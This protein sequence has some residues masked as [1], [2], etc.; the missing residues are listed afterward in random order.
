MH[1]S[2]RYWF[3]HE[4]KPYERLPYVSIPEA[5]SGRFYWQGDDVRGKQIR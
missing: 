1:S 4:L 3:V 2:F 5:E